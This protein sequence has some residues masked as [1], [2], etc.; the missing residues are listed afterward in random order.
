MSVLLLDDLTRR[1]CSCVF[2]IARF[3]F[4]QLDEGQRHERIVRPFGSTESVWTLLDNI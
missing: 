3:G 2:I 4:A 1:L